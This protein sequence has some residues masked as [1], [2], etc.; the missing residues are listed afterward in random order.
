T[1]PSGGPLP[2]TTVPMGSA[3]LRHSLREDL[4]DRGSSL[5]RGPGIRPEIRLAERRPP[6]R[7]GRREGR[8]REAAR[9]G[10][11]PPAARPGGGGTRRAGRRGREPIGPRDATRGTRRDRAGT[12]GENPA[13]RRTE[14]TASAPGR[15]RR[16]GRLAPRAVSERS[17]AHRERPG[18]RAERRVHEALSREAA[19]RLRRHDRVGGQAAPPGGVRPGEG[20]PRLGRRRVRRGPVQERPDPVALRMGGEAPRDWRGVR[21]RVRRETLRKNRE[22]MRACVHRIQD[23]DETIAMWK[24]ML[25]G[26]YGEGEAVVRLKTDMAHPNPAFRDRVLFRVAVREHPRVGTRYRVWPMLEFSW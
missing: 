1:R 5:R 17:A 22:A 21:V 2:R 20:R 24:A 7:Q 15:R 12:A 13:R 18:V 3:R 11:V 4:T 6:R 19:P 9:G 16:E 8:A 23:V 25:A 26:E 10:R 14:G